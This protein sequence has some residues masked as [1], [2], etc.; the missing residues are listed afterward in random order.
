MLR[1][2]TIKEAAAELRAMDAK[3]AITETHIRRLVLSGEVPSFKAGKK[4]LLNMDALLQYFEA[5]QAVPP[6]PAEHKIPRI[7]VRVRW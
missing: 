6:Q 1:M 4:Y 5:V 2:R 3:T 7:P